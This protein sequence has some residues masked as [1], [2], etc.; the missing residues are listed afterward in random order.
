MLDVAL[1]VV[2]ETQRPSFESLQE[3]LPREWI[4]AALDATGKAT[5][6]KRRLPAEQVALLV[7]AMA[8]ERSI[9][10]DRV[11][12][13]CQIALGS[14][15]HGLVAKSSI[16]AARDRLGAEPIAWLFDQTARCWAHRSASELRWRGLA[17][18][19]VDGT[20]LSTPDTPANEERFGRRAGTKPAGFPGVRLAVLMAV[21]TRSIAAARFGGIVR[22]ELELCDTLWNEIPH[23]S[24]TLI[25]RG[26]AWAPTFHRLASGAANRHWM[27]RARSNARWRRVKELGTGEELVEISAPWS[28]IKKYPD[29][30]PT[31]LAR[32]IHYQYAGAKKS[33]LLTSLTDAAAYPAKE[34]IA[35][36][37][38]RWEI[39]LGFDELKTHLNAAQTLRSKT[40]TLV[41]Q[42][43]WGLLLA[44]NMIR[45]QMKE[46]AKAIGISPLR[47]SFVVMVDLVRSRFVVP[48]WYAPGR[49]GEHLRTLCA[50]TKRLLLPARR[51]ERRYSRTV[52]RCTPYQ[53]RRNGERA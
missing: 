52:K 53:R 33:V 38:E 31:Y 17:L 29:L 24:L 9:S 25:D 39:E 4:R 48:T 28:T 18:Y 50:L 6:R 7:I 14:E 13:H 41:E 11:V 23:D 15:Q 40:P 42:E 2:S 34:L 45:E 37:H 5:M 1:A 12:D 3:A 46:V 10:I 44:Y 47:I 20:T 43:I 36:Y 32:A 49:V 51:P 26:L 21:R 22:P 27:T 30:P 19:A 35:L 16:P 8:I